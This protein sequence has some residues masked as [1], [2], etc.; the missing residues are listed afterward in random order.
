VLS[1]LHHLPPPPTSTSCK[2][3]ASP[4]IKFIT[5]RMLPKWSHTGWDLKDRVS[6]SNTPCVNSS[7]LF[8]AE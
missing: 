5:S 1:Q 8:A 4:S 2:Q 6:L 7:F 3:Q